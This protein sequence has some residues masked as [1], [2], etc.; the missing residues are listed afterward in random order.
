MNVLQL[1]LRHALRHMARTP[2]LTSMIVL[3]L[4]LGIGA[5][6]AIFSL[7]NGV[8]LRPL[9]YAD[10]DR[11]LQ[12]RY[13]AT[14]E[15]T[16]TYSF[17]VPELF[18]YR[19]QSRTLRSLSEYHSMTFTLLGG[20][21]P[22]RVRTGVVSAE[23]F[24]TMGIRPYLGRTFRPGEDRPEAARVL[25]LSYDLWRRRFL[26][27][28]AV[29]GKMLRMN[30][31]SLTVV[32]VLPPLPQYPGED[33]LYVT[34][35]SCPARSSEHFSH[36]RKIHELMLF[37]RIE[38]GATLKQAQAEVATVAGRLRQEFPEHYSGVRTANVT[39]VPI[40]ELLVAKIRPTIFI[41]LATVGLVLLT[42]CANLAN[43][44]LARL[45]R[46]ERE[47]VLRVALGAGRGRLIRQLL[48]ESILL[49]LLGGFLG[50]VLAAAGSGVLASFARLFT[51]R[52]Q[53]IE[54]DAHVLVFNLLVSILTG[55]GFGLI[56]ALQ[57]T[58]CNLAGFLKAGG[59]ATLGAARQRFR[60][61]LVM[62]QVALA[63]VL[64]T[65]AGLMVRS[66][67]ELQ[68]VDAG[69][70]PANVLSLRVPLPF[71]KYGPEESLQFFQRLL[72]EVR[73]H[74]AVRSAA[75]ATS[76]PL[77]G[78]QSVRSVHIEGQPIV[79]RE[80]LPQ[81]DFW[82]V[83]PDYFKTLGIPLLQGRVFTDSD[84]DAGPPVAVVS[85]S[86]AR[87]SWPGQ[88]PIGRRI[89]SPSIANGM[90]LTVI[91]V[92]DDV[93][94]AGLEIEPK[95]A[96]YLS[97]LQTG[98]MEMSVLVRTVGDP[99]ILVNEIRRAVH[100]LDPEQPVAD[101]RTLAEIRSRSIAPSRLRA[102]LLAVF[103]L[104]AFTI[105]AIGLNGVVA[106]M[107]GQR[108]P[109]IGLRMALGADRISL[110]RL[111]MRQGLLPVLL[112]LALG[113]AGAWAGGRLL[114][115]V[116]FGVQPADPFTFLATSLAL[117]ACAVAACFFPARRA[118]F[119]D[120]IVALR[121]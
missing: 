81:A 38:R 105:T 44:T 121:S 120:P 91:G 74:P 9:P 57:L 29:I 78:E 22:E 36:N 26:G 117:L 77:Y 31:L 112:G 119:I 110:L 12:L 3:T 48:T 71:N 39:L 89:S 94:Q 75:V 76:F 62:V 92:V 116:L 28:P 6:T 13:A 30:G 70:D 15:G 88:S 109:E 69:F 97:F 58:R 115:S 1:D 90:G 56:P 55:I 17:S 34:L 47:I 93:R 73:R 64:L 60:S 14:A 108:T 114:A 82:M 11:L 51:P 35:P 24:D 42:A 104:L 84:T 16:D 68:G 40:Q 54:I 86:L 87:R 63:F 46:R 4:A 32:G 7:A 2:W 5:N 27:D 66:L 41:L 37:G 25:V 50:L 80:E 33:D 19:R 21:E 61:A 85:R 23:F 96:F 8:L 67:Y 59:A 107:V 118:A 52:A 98:G 49:S 99:A 20:G 45:I 102:G 111:V 18:E 43:L 83:S 113:W 101:I 53:N 65:G 106:F 95:D 72:A 100:A 10:A 103:A 79:P